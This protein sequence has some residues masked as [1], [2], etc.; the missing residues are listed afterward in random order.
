VTRDADSWLAS[1]YLQMSPPRK[2]ESKE[3]A[4]RALAL[5]PDFW[6]VKTQALPKTM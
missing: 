4:N 5:G 6:Y 2:T 1:L 3:M